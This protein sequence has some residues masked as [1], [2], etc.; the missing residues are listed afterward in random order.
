M[1]FAPLLGLIALIALSACGPDQTDMAV[2]VQ[3]VGGQL[4]YGAATLADAKRNFFG[5]A[6]GSGTGDDGGGKGAAKDGDGLLDSQ[7]VVRLHGPPPTVTALT[8]TRADSLGGNTVLRTSAQ[9]GYHHLRGSLPDGFGILTDPLQIEIRAQSLGVQ[10]TLGHIHDLPSGL[11]VAYE[12]GLGVTRLAA[13]THLR[14]A[15]LD[16]R[17]TSLQILPYAVAEGRISGQTGPA[18]LGSL[19]VFTTGATEFRVGLEQS[20]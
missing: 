3:A 15:L 1:T 17:G 11:R 8:F 18:V 5:D 10:M 16:L 7:D 12:G 19:S 9:I 20:F 14:S 13:T 4:A 2:Q 6:A